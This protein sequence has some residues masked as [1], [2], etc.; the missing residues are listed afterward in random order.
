MYCYIVKVAISR[1]LQY[2]TQK[3]PDDY[4]LSQNMLPALS[5]LLLVCC[6]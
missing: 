1:L 5:C 6:V 2:C 4:F 3:S